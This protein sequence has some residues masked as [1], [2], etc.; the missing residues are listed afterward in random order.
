MLAAGLA[1]ALTRRRLQRRLQLA[2]QQVGLERE[3]TRIARDI[4]DDLGANL[5]QISLLSA[6]GREQRD[7][8][9]AVEAKFAAI[10]TV[11]GE[12][13]QALDAIVWAVNPRHDTLESLARYLV[14]FSSDLCVHAPVRLR[15]Q[16]AVNAGQLTLSLSDDGCGFVPEPAT[17]AAVAGVGNGVHNMRQRLAEIGG[18]CEITSA[19]GKGAHIVFYLP[20]SPLP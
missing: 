18:R 7:Q 2:E 10:T 13:V 11:A 20:C 6:V 8:P 4:H 16:L 15:L 5:T 14:R 19:P 9:E 12:L 3:R 17:G 1:R